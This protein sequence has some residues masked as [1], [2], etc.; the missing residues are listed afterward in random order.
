MDP[1]PVSEHM[2]VQC[3]LPYMRSGMNREVQSRE[4]YQRD[5]LVSSKRM[6]YAVYYQYLLSTSTT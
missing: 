2:H 1:R 6:V 5:L 4:D 3:E